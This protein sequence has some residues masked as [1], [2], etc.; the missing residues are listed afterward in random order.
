[1]NKQNSFILYP[2]Q[3]Y[4]I[5]KVS[6]LS[7]I[8]CAYAIYQGYTD[9]SLVPGGVL[10]TSL[11]YW[12]NPDYSWKRTLDM[13]YVRFA[14][15]YQIIRSYEAEYA[16]PHLICMILAVSCF[17]LSWKYYNNNRWWDSVYIH[18]LVH[19]L[20]NIGNIILYSGNIQPIEN[21]PI[22]KLVL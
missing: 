21:N 6:W 18:C 2:D 11:N 14:L 12:R 22:L 17:P 7:L 16:V 4:Y 5:W 10:I 19:I 13:N 8:S 1:M 9:L 15:S 20:G 3:S